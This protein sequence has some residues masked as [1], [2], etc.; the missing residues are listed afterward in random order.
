MRAA[1]QPEPARG[2]IDLDAGSAG[3]A[4]AQAR[5]ALQCCR[6]PVSGGCSERFVCRCD[7]RPLQSFVQCFR[8]AQLDFWRAWG[9]VCCSLPSLILLLHAFSCRAA[10][11]C[12]YRIGVNGGVAPCSNPFAISSPAPC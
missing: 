9:P 12:V 7:A 4:A 1:C 2:S 11:T 10:R 5:V 6:V 3:A 8:D